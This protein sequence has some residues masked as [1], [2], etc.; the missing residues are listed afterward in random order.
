MVADSRCLSSSFWSDIGVRSGRWGLSLS[1]EDGMVAS[2]S[3]LTCIRLLIRPDH[4]LEWSRW[5]FWWVVMVVFLL[6]GEGGMQRSRGYAN[7]EMWESVWVGEEYIMTITGLGATRA[8]HT[9]DK[10]WRA[11]DRDRTREEEPDALVL[12]PLHTLECESW[13][14]L[15]PWAKY[16]NQ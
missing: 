5:W 6:L 8:L 14:V 3:S 1:S 15:A 4:T 13:L 9:S 7:L 11:S 10:M 16:V 2:E 12:L